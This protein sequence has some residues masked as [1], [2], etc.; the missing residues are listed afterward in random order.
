MGWDTVD[1]LSIVLLLGSAVQ[2]GYGRNGVDDVEDVP[3]RG[4]GTVGDMV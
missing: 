2:L 1:Q 3:L 4:K